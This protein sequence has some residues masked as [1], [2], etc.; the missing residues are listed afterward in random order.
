M[1]INIVFMTGQF[2]FY[3]AII[4]KLAK[5]DHPFPLSNFDKYH[6]VDEIVNSSFKS[7]FE[8][9]TIIIV[10]VDLLVKYKDIFVKL[11]DL[12]PD[13]KVLLIKPDVDYLG[14]SKLIHFN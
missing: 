4:T 3:S 9:C 8:N 11:Q 1:G 7:L 5:N 12:F 2:G 13:K 14:L 6:N 10:T